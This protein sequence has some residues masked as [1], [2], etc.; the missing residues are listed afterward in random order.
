MVVTGSL[1]GGYVYWF[2]EFEAPAGFVTP[3][4]PASLS[5]AFV[6]DAGAGE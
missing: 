6:P 5:V 1:E 2:N 3:E 4:W